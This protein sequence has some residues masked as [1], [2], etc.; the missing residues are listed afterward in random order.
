MEYFPAYHQSWKIRK[1]INQHADYADEHDDETYPHLLL[2]C[3]N[4]STEKRVI[5]FTADMIADFEIFT[6]TKERLLSNEK[7]VWLK[8]YEVDWDEEL[9]FHSMPLRLE[10]QS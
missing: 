8:P 6:T 10:E 9:E 7:K 4:S 3:G 5:R 2:V 1:R